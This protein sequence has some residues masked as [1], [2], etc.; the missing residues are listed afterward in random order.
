[1][2]TDWNF[3]H[4]VYQT[5]VEAVLAISAL[6]SAGAGV[7]SATHKPK[8]PEIKPID[9]TVNVQNQTSAQTL[10]DQTVSTQNKRQTARK[11]TK[12]LLIPLE[13]KKTGLTT[14]GGTGLNI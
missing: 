10:K 7:Y 11:G 8:I 12:K 9:T 2:K 5:G 1:M 13:A 6:A 3:E 4:N 14:T